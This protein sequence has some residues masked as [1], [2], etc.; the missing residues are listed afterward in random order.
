MSLR[1]IRDVLEARKQNGDSWPT[2][3]LIYSW[4][5]FNYK[6]FCDRCIRRFG[7]KL[8]VDTEQ[9]DSWLQEVS[10]L[11]KGVSDEK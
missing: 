3:G 1:Q 6:G 8:L 9:F 2:R 5:F 7:R 4:K 10:E 11:V